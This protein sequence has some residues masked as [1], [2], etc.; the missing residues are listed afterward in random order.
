[1]RP[2]PLFLCYLEWLTGTRPRGEATAVHT[3]CL[4]DARPVTCQHLCSV[5]FLISW[6]FLLFGHCAVNT[7]SCV[8]ASLSS[9]LFFSPSFSFLHPGLHVA[10]PGSKGPT[11]REGESTLSPLSFCPSLCFGIDWGWG[12]VRGPGSALLLAHGRSRAASQACCT[13]AVSHGLVS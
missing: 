9:F 4:L 13:L 10:A 11:G 1:M 2:L 12:A 6:R 8:C 5:L 3:L 7:D